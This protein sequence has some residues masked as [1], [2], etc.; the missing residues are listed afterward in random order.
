[1]SEDAHHYK[2]ELEDCT[3]G[4]HNLI[5]NTFEKNP[6]QANLTLIVT[7]KPRLTDTI[8]ELELSADIGG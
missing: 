3:D 7:V 8:S 4:S 6:D 5:R 2:Q 1:M